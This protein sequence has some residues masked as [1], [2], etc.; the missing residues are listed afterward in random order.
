MKFKEFE[1]AHGVLNT[2]LHLYVDTQGFMYHALS[3]KPSHHCRLISG[4]RHSHKKYYTPRPLS[5]FDTQHRQHLFTSFHNNNSSSLQREL[6]DINNKS[7]W[8]EKC[9]IHLQNQLNNNISCTIHNKSSYHN[10]TAFMVNVVPNS[11]SELLD[12]S[13][14]PVTTSNIQHS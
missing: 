5:S 12:L 10:E 8:L 3:P 13:T 7:A 4:T 1:T 9:H 2:Q 11:S 6:S 14:E